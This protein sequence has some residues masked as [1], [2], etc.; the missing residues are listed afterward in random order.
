MINETKY[1]IQSK[2]KFGVLIYCACLKYTHGSLNLN[3]N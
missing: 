1:Q 3:D 2:I